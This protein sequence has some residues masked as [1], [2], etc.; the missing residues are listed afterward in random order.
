MIQSLSRLQS[1]TILLIILAV[2]L[3]SRL[4]AAIYMGN[5]VELLPGTYDQVSYHNLALRLLDGHAFSFAEPWWPLTRAG[6]PTAHWSYLYTAFLT[7]VYA[8]TG[9]SPLIARIV[10]VLAVGLLHPYLIY[11]IGRT[12]F[13][14]K[15][16]LLAA[17]LTAVYTYFIY[18]SATLMTEPF[19][20]TAI[21]ASLYLLI[22][23][24]RQ[25]APPTWKQG[26]L[27]GLLFGAAVL[28]RQLFLLLLPFLMVWLW[29]A[30]RQRGE[31][32]PFAVTVAAALTVI[33]MIIPFTLYNYARFDRLVLLN[34]NAGFAFYWANH[35]I[36]GDQFQPILPPEMGTYQELIPTELRRLDEAALDQALLQR[37]MQLISDDPMRYMRLSLSRIPPYFMFWPSADSGLISNIA[38]VSSFGLLWPFMLG[39]VILTF[40]RKKWGQIITHPASLLLLFAVIY[41]VIHILS[42]TLIRYRLPVDAVMLTFAAAALMA[43]VARVG[44]RRHVQTAN[45]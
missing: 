3:L 41:T 23:L 1:R 42:W 38:R 19:Y 24:S 11:H 16:G 33:A 9:A 43:I 7:V 4:A 34:T 10:Q 5:G 20:I 31:G 26:I 40:W 30:R 13:N 29:L 22:R 14:Q 21:L 39:G 37:A 28:L 15:I 8:V 27:L 2:S 44:A 45:I 17:A 25:D 36:Y 6:A 35:P 32:I 12:A 18:Y